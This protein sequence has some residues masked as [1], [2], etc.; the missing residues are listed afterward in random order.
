MKKIK[1]L[2]LK[3]DETKLYDEESRN[4]YVSIMGIVG[5]FIIL[6]IIVLNIISLW[7]YE[8]GFI[9]P[10]SSFVES[11]IK[12][13]NFIW[14]F[15]FLILTV[16]L[17]LLGRI[18]YLFNWNSKIESNYYINKFIYYILNFFLNFSVIVSD[19]NLIEK[20]TSRLN[21]LNKG[22]NKF[23]IWYQNYSKYEFL[24]ISD[25][26]E[27][28]KLEFIWCIIPT[29]I[30][31][32]IAGPSFSLVFSL[33]SVVN[34]EINIKVTGRQWYWVYS[35]DNMTIFDDG[36]KDIMFNYDSNMI[37]DS[38][39]NKGAHRLLEVNNKLILPV[40]VPIRFLI[41]S[42]DVLHSWA[43]PAFGLKV[44]AV[45]GRLNQF[46]VEIK[47]PGIFYGQCSELCGSMHGF[48]PITIQAIN[49]DE[50]KEWLKNL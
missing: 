42:M 43:V 18:I 4:Y 22:S 26:H 24:L 2:N 33:D 15:L 12:L 30:L 9:D 11:L 23:N 13:Y 27:Y 19:K 3:W 29:L 10:S 45:P 14:C 1:E 49:Y 40:G 5:L 32:L 38:D 17:I 25:L 41:T 8:V 39:L 20:L 31:I 21:E 48:M 16:I 36:K 50:Y 46:I 28:K 35:Y 7:N 37:I 44:D 34:P 47:K 6:T